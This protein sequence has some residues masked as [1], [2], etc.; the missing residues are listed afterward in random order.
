MGKLGVG[1]VFLRRI[2]TTA[3]TTPMMM[4]P[5]AIPTPNPLMRSHSEGGACTCV[6][7]TCVPVCVPVAVMPWDAPWRVLIA[8][9]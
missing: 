4:I 8:C 3:K 5:T 7:V 1:G 9:T 2:R 6:C